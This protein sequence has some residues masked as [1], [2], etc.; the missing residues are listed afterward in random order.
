VAVVKPR[1]PDDAAGEGFALQV[2]ALRA[3]VAMRTRRSATVEQ[4]EWELEP[5]KP[6]C[7][8][9]WQSSAYPTGYCLQIVALKDD[10][11]ET[12]PMDAPKISWAVYK[13]RGYRTVVM[14]GQAPSFQVGQ[15][16]AEAIWRIDAG[17]RADA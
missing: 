14:G 13:G 9:E 7:E 16:R 5:V 8:L 6:G 15:A 3:R 2:A 11:L 17:L 1:R 4:A 10:F 12:L